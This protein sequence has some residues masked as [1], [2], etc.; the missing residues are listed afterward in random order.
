MVLRS[1]WQD[2]E[3]T[4]DGFLVHGQEEEEEEDEEGQA[5]S[6]GEHDDEE[7]VEAPTA[8]REA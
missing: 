5:E 7:D 1:F 8:V 6:T 3:L 2:D 4:A